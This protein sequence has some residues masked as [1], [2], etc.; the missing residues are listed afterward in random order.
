MQQQ[1]PGHT[2][3]RCAPK[4]LL[5]SGSS[6]KQLPGDCLLKASNAGAGTQEFSHPGRMPRLHA[7]KG[8]QTTNHKQ[9]RQ[10]F[11]KA[12]LFFNQIQLT[13]VTQAQVAQTGRHADTIARS[14]SSQNAVLD[15]DV[16]PNFEMP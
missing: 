2:K 12:E 15:P 16:L 1:K 8:D 10:D 5:V 6:G 13:T 3:N 11:V 7:D 14:M 4:F 9:H